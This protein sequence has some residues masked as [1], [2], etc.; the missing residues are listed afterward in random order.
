MK[1][2]ELLYSWIIVV[3]SGVIFSLLLNHH[4]ICYLRQSL[5]HKMSFSYKMSYSIL[6][7]TSDEL[8]M[9]IK[10]YNFF[11]SAEV[12]RIVQP[13]YSSRIESEF[14]IVPVLQV[15]TESLLAKDSH[16][17]LG[18][19]QN[20]GQYITFSP[21]EHQLLS[22]LICSIYYLNHAFSIHTIEMINNFRTKIFAANKAVRLASIL[23]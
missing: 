20:I 21:H 6:Y 5:T 7:S 4:V 19:V 18:H 22:E 17:T 1:F 10:S 2:V 13:S 16:S 11:L 3:Y 9:E 23:W 14:D 15:E 12:K 8:W